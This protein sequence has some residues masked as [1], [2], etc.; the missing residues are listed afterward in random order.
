MRYA[1]KRRKLGEL[2]VKKGRLTP[3]SLSGYLRE[4]KE[5]GQPLGQILVKAEIL[6]DDELTKILGEQL[7]LPHVWLR[8][9]L[10]DPQI[11]HL[12]PKA[13]AQRFQVIPMF[14][15]EDQ[16]IWARQ[17]PTRSSSSTRWL[18]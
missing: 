12:L 1:T 7:G 5:Q 18:G 16:L 4:Q 10:V 15:I 9:G 6:T 11:V 2:L 13:K 14:R 17:T 8:K 3:E